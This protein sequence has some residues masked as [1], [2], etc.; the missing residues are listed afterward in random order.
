MQFAEVLLPPRNVAPVALV[1]MTTLY[2]LMN[3]GREILSATRLFKHWVRVFE[4]SYFS[5]YNL[6]KRRMVF[7]KLKAHL[8]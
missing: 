8:F 1:G 4:T 2:P 3:P 6:K 7:K 5:R